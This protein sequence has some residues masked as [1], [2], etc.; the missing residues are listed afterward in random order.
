MYAFALNDPGNGVDFLGLQ[1]AYPY[2]MPKLCCK[3]ETFADVD[4]DIDLLKTREGK[5]RWEPRGHADWGK[6]GVTIYE[7]PN[8][9]DL[10]VVGSVSCKRRNED[11]SV[12]ILAIVPVGPFT[13]THKFNVGL[14]FGVKWKWKLLTDVSAVIDSAKKAI[15][16]K[17]EADNLCDSYF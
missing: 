11:C 1:F 17:I 12:E 8:E 14:G 15:I 13:Y 16:G 4:V 9:A 10:N 3:V 5:G 6:I 7:V 2:K